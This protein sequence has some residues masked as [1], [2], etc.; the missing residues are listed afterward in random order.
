MRLRAARGMGPRAVGMEIHPGVAFGH[1]QTEGGGMDR[2]RDIGWA[3]LA[4]AN[5][6][7][8]PRRTAMAAPRCRA[9]P[10]SIGRE[11]GS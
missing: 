11:V 3:A 10:S 5:A 7:A 4:A 9:V 1:P 2:R 6:R 8:A